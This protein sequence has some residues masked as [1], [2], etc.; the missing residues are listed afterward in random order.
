[1]NKDKLGGYS[2]ILGGISFFYLIMLAIESKSPGIFIGSMSI[3][4][5]CFGVMTFIK[6]GQGKIPAS[7]GIVLGLLCLISA[8]T[9]LF[10]PEKKLNFNPGYKDV[11]F[12]ENGN[13][14]GLRYCN[15]Y[16]DCF[17]K[18]TYDVSTQKFNKQEANNKLDEYSFS[19]DGRK[20][21]FIDGSED[22]K[23]IFMMNADGNEKRQLTHSSDMDTVIVKDNFDYKSMYVKTNSCPSFAPDGKRVIFV[24]HT[25][26]VK[27][28]SGTSYSRDCDVYD[29]DIET[30]VERKLTNYNFYGV[31][32]PRYFSD[33]K[34]FIFS[35]YILKP[36]IYK[37]YE[38]KYKG[39]NI[40]IMDENNNEL[41][42]AIRHSSFSKTPSISFDDKITYIANPDNVGYYSSEVFIKIGDEIKQLTN[43]KSVIIFSEISSDSKCIVYKE[44]R[45]IGKDALR[46]NH[47][48]IMNS[49]GTGLKELI[50]PKD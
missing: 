44:E 6:K 1:M 9:N 34:H 3:G 4:A 33:G 18:Y 49:D 5:I 35:G 19:R 15:S 45:K 27:N 48:W 13:I 32:C 47:F 24:R 22:E 30:G 8:F 31:S 17:I 39:N 11:C 20:I 42:P 29:I 23:N 10:F 7:I 50:P 28:R 38:A 37:A 14:V 12:L 26:R 43:M 40:F 25:F 16:K 46:E 36:E 2:L 41:R 21:L